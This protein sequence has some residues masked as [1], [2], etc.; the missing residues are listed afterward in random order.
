VQASTVFYD[1]PATL[2]THALAFPIPP[3]FFR[4]YECVCGR[5]RARGT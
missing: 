3:L 2:G 4:E 5:A 1:T